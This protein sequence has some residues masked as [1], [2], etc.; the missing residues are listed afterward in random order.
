M[1]TVT[2][3]QTI[4]S[5]AFA[6]IYIYT[7]IKILLQKKIDFSQCIRKYH[8]ILLIFTFI[9][10]TNFNAWYVMWLFPTIF[11]LRGKSV[12]TVLYLSYAC[13]IANIMNFALFSEDEELG[14]PYVIIMF[15]VTFVLAKGSKR[16][17]L[18]EK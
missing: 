5:I 13:T 1:N 8:I 4:V 18:K 16:K 9:V 3:I 11:W 10:I 2:T 17:E 15:V 6:V 14:I 7:V 12:K